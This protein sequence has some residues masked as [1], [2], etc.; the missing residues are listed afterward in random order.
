MKRRNSFIILTCCIL[1][2]VNGCS[3]FINNKRDPVLSPSIQKALT[4]YVENSDIP[5]NYYEEECKYIEIYFV[6]DT[7]FL[8]PSCSPGVP[9]GERL[10]FGEVSSLGRTY[11][12]YKTPFIPESQISLFFYQIRKLTQHR[13]K[14]RVRKERANIEDYSPGVFIIDGQNLIPL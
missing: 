12:I 10:Y 5:Y 8:F 7:L 14:R 3:V 2:V 4:Y 1:L 13:L 11:V 9:Y 6:D